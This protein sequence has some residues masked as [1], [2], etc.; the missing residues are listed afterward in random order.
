MQRF[1]AAH[2]AGLGDKS[3]SPQTT[4]RQAWFP[5]MIAID[6]LQKRHPDAGRFLMWSLL[7]APTIAERTV[8]RVRAL[9]KRVY[10]DIPHVARRQPKKP[11]GPHPDKASQPP[12]YWFRDGRMMDFAFD[13]VQWGS[14]LLLDGSSRTIL[15]GAL[16]PSE[17]SWATLMGLYTACARYGAPQTLISDSGGAY[18][19]TEFEAVCPR[20][21]IDHP[22]IVS[23]QGESSMNLME[24]HFNIQRR[25]YDYQF[26]LSQN[27]VELEQTH[28]AFL[29]TYNTTAHQ[30]L[31][32]D[33]FDPP[34]PS[35]VL[36]EAQG[37]MYS[38]E[39]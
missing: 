38:Q 30:G 20:L 36:A 3:S 13:S 1:E 37:R 32:K 22:T 11:P 34:I 12:Q 29:Q 17:A 7:A 31:L 35:G 5:L 4:T 26:S 14:I 10:D 24:T 39:E 16:A 18:I 19:A 28:Q 9:N 27:P 8:G 23:P 33:G 25:L 21:E 15:A 6:H 2:V